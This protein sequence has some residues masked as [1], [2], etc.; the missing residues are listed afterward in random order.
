MTLGAFLVAAAVIIVL[1]IALALVQRFV[2]GFDATAGAIV[3]WVLIIA[4]VICAVLWL[5]HVIGGS[6][7]DPTL[8]DVRH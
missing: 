3:K 1:L 4:L 2:P 7:P 5:W 6:V 8:R